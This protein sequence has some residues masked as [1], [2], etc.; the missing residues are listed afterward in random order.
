MKQPMA[1]L[2]AKRRQGIACCILLVQALLLGCSGREPDSQI[3]FVGKWMSSR[4][5]TPIHLHRNGEWEIVTEDGTILQY[6]VW[7]YQNA[8]ILWSYKG[9]GGAEHDLTPVLS[10]TPREFRLRERNG[11]ETTFV[12]LD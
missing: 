8:A 11:N 10:T 4:S 3:S 7:Q 12:K 2:L 6:G 1:Q 5:M 9:R